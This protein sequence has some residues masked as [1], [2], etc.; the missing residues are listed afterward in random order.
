M[1][2]LNFLL[3]LKD[4]GEQSRDSKSLLNKKSFYAKLDRIVMNIE[5]L[6]EELNQ[7]YLD[8][9]ENTNQS[10]AGMCLL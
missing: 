9:L 2:L 5:Y 4:H 6:L 1:M 10:K 3:A 7:E 8:F